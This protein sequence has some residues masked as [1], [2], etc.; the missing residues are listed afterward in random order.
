MRKGIKLDVRGVHEAF[1]LSDG[2][3]QIW[4]NNPT[5]EDGVAIFLDGEE[6]N[7]LCDW[8]QSGKDTLQTPALE[9]QP[10]TSDTVLEDG[11]E[12]YLYN[13]DRRMW[14]GSRGEPAS[15]SLYTHYC[16]APGLPPFPEPDTAPDEDSAMSKEQLVADTAE[17]FLAMWHIHLETVEEMARE[18]YSKGVG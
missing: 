6:M 11:E 3:F 10:I 2:M 16:Q 14:T 8:W 5:D 13:I 17:S 12:Y 18:Y 4:K 9:W 7:A 1:E 15:R